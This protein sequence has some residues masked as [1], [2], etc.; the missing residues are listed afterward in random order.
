MSLLEHNTIRKERVD[1]KVIE[2]ETGDS[3]KY[4]IEA[5]QDNAVYTSK[6]KGHLPGLYHLLV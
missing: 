3:E 2:L 5:I 6:A 4:K 1:K